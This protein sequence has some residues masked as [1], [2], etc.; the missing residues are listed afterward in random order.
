MT[1]GRGQGL[2]RAAVAVGKLEAL[3]HDAAASALFGASVANGYVMAVEGGAKTAV[4]M[5]VAGLK[6]GAKRKRK[7]DRRKARARETV[8]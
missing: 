7:S 1:G 5:I 3:D 2:R 4:R 8:A 6:L